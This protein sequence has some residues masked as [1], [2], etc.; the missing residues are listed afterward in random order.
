MVEVRAA[1]T[2]SYCSLITLSPLAFLLSLCLHP[3]LFFGV[4][5][6]E[7]DLLWPRCSSGLPCKVRCHSLL[8]SKG[9]SNT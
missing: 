2:F 1:P 7:F 9:S 6:A 8:A 4:K 5:G 3:F